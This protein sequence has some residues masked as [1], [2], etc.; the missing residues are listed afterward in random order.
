MQ[1]SGWRSVFGVHWAAEVFPPL[2]APELRALGED[3]RDHGM[4]TSIKLILIAGA[5]AVI[6]GRQR[7]DSMELVGLPVIV[8]EDFADGIHCEFVGSLPGFDPVAY[9]VSLGLRCRHMN[10][11]Q[12]AMV[13]A[14]LATRTVGSPLQTQQEAPTRKQAAAML[15]VTEGNVEHAR[16][17]VKRGE[18]ALI[19]AVE[20]GKIKTRTAAKIATLPPAEQLAAVESVARPVKQSTIERRERR[21][22]MPERQIAKPMPR[23]DTEDIRTFI[24]S[25]MLRR[26]EMA[27]IPKTERVALARSFAVAM[28][29]VEQDAEHSITGS[30]LA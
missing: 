18:P 7:L 21:G 15:N 13:A 11:A 22:T 4:I 24:D 26:E 8:G 27:A 1:P 3:I 12:R 14:K 17:V 19:A 29:L 10:E 20:Q 30:G 28:Q 6:D 16:R 9:V 5:A 2:P 23:V 25:L